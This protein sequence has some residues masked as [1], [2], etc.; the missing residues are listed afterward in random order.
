MKYFVPLILILI[1]CSLQTTVTAQSVA[2]YIAPNGNDEASGY[3]PKEAFATLEKARDVIR[4][5]RKQSGS[6][7]IFV[8]LLGGEYRLKQTFQLSLED[9]GTQEAPI[10]YSAL[11]GEKVVLNGGERITEWKKYKNNIW[12]A[13]V[14]QVKKGN[15]SF[16]Q[17]FVN[18]ES[19]KI[20]S[21]PKKGFYRVKG[22][23]D[24]GLDAGYQT[25]GKRFI[26]NSEDIKASWKN[27]KDIDVVVYHFW[28]DT[29]L[30]IESVDEKEHLVN[31]K[32]PSGKVFT[33]D[34][35]N[36]GARYVVENVWE[37][38]QDPGDWYLDKKKGK[39]Y[40]I[41]F[42]TENMET[43]EVW[44]P[45][46][47][48]FVD[49]AGDA[50]N[51]KPVSDIQFKN[52]TFQYANVQL[53]KG[54]TNNAQ[55][56]SSIAAVIK[57]RGAQRCVFHNCTINN[58]GGFAFDIQEGS[59][60]NEFSYNKLLNIAA[61][62]FRINGGT[63]TRH[64]LLQTHHNIISDNE[65][66][67]YGLK[68]PSAVGVLIMHGRNNE[69]IHNHIHHGFYTGVSVG[70][71]WGYQRSISRDNIVAD[72]YI[73]HIGQGLLS[74]MGAVYTLGVS[75]GTVIRNNLIHDVDA[76]N[77]GGWGIYNDEGSTHILVENNIVYN[78]K[79]AGY[80]INY[81]KEITVRNNIFALGRLQQINRNS[82]EPHQSV[83][84]ENNIIYWKEGVLFDGNWE[85]KP[86]NF[87][88]D[89]DPKNGT[90]KMSSTFE[91]DYNIYF[92]PLHAADSITFNKLRF[93]EWQQKGKDRHS[94][95]ADPLFTDPEHFDFTLKAN[96]PAFKMG[97]QPFNMENVGPRTRNR[98]K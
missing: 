19:R 11:T 20:A 78:T 22:F 89:T 60:Y 39:L 27:L 33:D 28:T 73:H 87:Y 35:N 5:Q 18:G 24:G 2:Y 58:I 31:F 90:R 52:I 42:A 54:N 75:P 86:Y 13:N 34:F 1:G 44:A 41:P 38:L 16:N 79:F 10:I 3:S 6:D 7:T 59:S 85:D 57:L 49:I 23:P 92:N 72:N 9:G 77:Y 83:Y 53:P 46:I 48:A 15:W 26:Y 88:F 51:G 91:T 50:V 4:M 55:G 56:S 71:E 32:Y 68:F 17:L 14:P 64:P 94:L 67:P 62:G 96:S 63:S 93:N 29:H 47:P 40:Y 74:D 37:G 21:L 66:G 43:I 45:A 82:V 25:P 36:E 12:V 98:D 95:Y 97:F 76:H 30:S 70:W 61:G 8:Y 80:N 81:A 69:V 84:F 65:I